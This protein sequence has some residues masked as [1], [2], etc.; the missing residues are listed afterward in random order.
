ME[1]P[2]AGV[3]MAAPISRCPVPADF[4]AEVFA[5]RGAV[6]SWNSTESC[7]IPLAPWEHRFG[8]RSEPT[9]KSCRRGQTHGMSGYGTCATHGLMRRWSASRFISDSNG[10]LAGRLSLTPKRSS[11]LRRLAPDGACLYGR[12]KPARRLLVR[13]RRSGGRMTKPRTVSHR[14]SGRTGMRLLIAMMQHETNT[15]SPVPTPLARFGGGRS[16]PRGAEAIAAYGGTG[17]AAGAY[18]DLA[19][20]IG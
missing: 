7:V 15:F 8:F 9:L 4:V 17:T 3:I 1:F 12:V 6:C 18:L 10:T 19:D 16:P 13:F 11:K 20:K 14:S 5:R 2:E